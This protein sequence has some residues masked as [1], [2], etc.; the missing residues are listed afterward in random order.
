[1]ATTLTGE[2]NVPEGPPAAKRPATPI[3]LRAPGTDASLIDLSACYNAALT[4]TWQ[5]CSGLFDLD[6]SLSSFPAG[7]TNLGGVCFDV[8]GV[9][10][11]GPAKGNLCGLPARV[12]IPIGRKFHRLH[13]L[14][15]LEERIPNGQHA[16]SYRLHY[17]DGDAVE[18]P[19]LYGRDARDW[20]AKPEPT[21]ADVA[22]RGSTEWLY[23][24]GALLCLY[25]R[26]YDNPS[27]EREVVRLTFESELEATGPFLVAMTVD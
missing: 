26:T 5:P 27:P 23:P 24:G 20:Q 18:L 22:W 14:H 9:V 3:P 11:L 21:T 8:R 13:V 7:I 16:G 15:A 25:K 10:R 4:E 17:A 6:F 1:V 2:V 12:E 19:I